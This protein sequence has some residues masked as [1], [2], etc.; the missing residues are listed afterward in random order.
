MTFKALTLSLLLRSDR[1]PAGHPDD[2]R[3]GHS[4][5]GIGKVSSEG[6]GVTSGGGKRGIAEQ[7]SDTGREAETADC[8]PGEGTDQSDAVY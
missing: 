4:G 1:K 3:G 6:Q 8:L 2:S 5:S 7:M